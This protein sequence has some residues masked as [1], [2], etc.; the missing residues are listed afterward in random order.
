MKVAKEL[1]GWTATTDVPVEGDLIVRF[2]TMKRSNGKLVTSAQAY[3]KQGN[4]ISYVMFQDY[5]R[6]LITSDSKR[7]TA[8]VVE[9][10]HSKI[11]V[12]DVVGLVRCFY[13]LE[14][15]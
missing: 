13:G 6:T 5:N 11:N 4:M 3:R 12:Q 1:R 8:K 7:V 15:V 10:Q 2:T 14:V 9:E